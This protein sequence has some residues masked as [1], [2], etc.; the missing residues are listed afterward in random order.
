MTDQYAGMYYADTDTIGHRPISIIS[1]LQPSNAQVYTIY[2][3]ALDKVR[4]YC[5]VSGNTTLLI[6]YYNS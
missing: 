6:T 3:S 2:V 5:S 1:I 4:A